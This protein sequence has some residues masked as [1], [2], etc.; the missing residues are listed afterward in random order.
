MNVSSEL[1]E[2]DDVINFRAAFIYAIGRLF[3][4]Y[5]KNSSNEFLSN[6]RK[7]LLDYKDSGFESLEYLSIKEEDLLKGDVLRKTL[8]LYNQ[9]M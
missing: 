5:I 3:G 4:V 1:Y 8:K 7:M 6:F 9:N 2:M